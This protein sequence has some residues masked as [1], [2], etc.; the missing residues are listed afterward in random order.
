MWKTPEVLYPLVLDLH[1][2]QVNAGVNGELVEQSVAE[3]KGYIVENNNNT[4]QIS[5]P[6]TAEGGY[7]K[8]RK[9]RL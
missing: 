6:Y 9:H 3:E 2:T 7:R 4:I 1:S 5:I 8:V